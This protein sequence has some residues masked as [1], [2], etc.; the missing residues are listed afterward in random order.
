M[1]IILN[2]IAV[3]LFAGVLAG[4]ASSGS[5]RMVARC[6]SPNAPTSLEGIS[7]AKHPHPRPEEQRLNRALTELLKRDDANTQSPT[8]ADYVLA[9]YI[10]ESWDEVIVTPRQEEP[11]NYETVV[12]VPG[13]KT[14]GRM[15]GEPFI[16][17]E[18]DTSPR[19]ISKKGVKLLL[20]SNRAPASERLTPVWEGYIEVSSTE[21]VQHLKAAVQS[22]LAQLG[23]DFIG[24]V[25]LQK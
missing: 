8:N 12:N 6:N 9:Y 17:I 2:L 18:R 14:E 7:L 20:Y 21:S 19:Y 22:L 23:K 16:P 24:R 3:L 10:E 15:A 13:D 11:Q 25:R 4:C 1:K 5:A